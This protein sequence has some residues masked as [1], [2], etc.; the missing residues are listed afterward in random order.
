MTYNEYEGT[1]DELIKEYIPYAFTI[2]RSLRYLKPHNLEGLQGEALLA[3]CESIKTIQAKPDEQIPAIIVTVIRRYL[4]EFTSKD[5]P[6]VIPRTTYLRNNETKL[7]RRNES[8]LMAC[9]AHISEQH[10]TCMISE[11][12]D[13]MHLTTKQRDLLELMLKDYTRAELAEI[14][15]V[16]C[17]RMTQLKYE[18][19]RKLLGYLRKNEVK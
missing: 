1:V 14:Y 13:D 7:L 9:S 5:A 16:S 6:V 3:L 12:I 19:K 17:S 2:A 18:I 11:I 4:Y 8:C 10:L 15:N